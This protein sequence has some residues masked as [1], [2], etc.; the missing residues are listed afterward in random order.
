ME[1]ETAI[2]TTPVDGTPAQTI[3]ILHSS[4]HLSSTHQV[5]NNKLFPQLNDCNLLTKLTG[6]NFIW[7]ILSSAPLDLTERFTLTI[8]ESN[9]RPLSLA[10]AAVA[11]F[12]PCCHI[13][14]N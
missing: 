3:T 1:T 2:T 4:F 9:S 13:A 7:T 5:T 6:G 11:P 12:C 8:T 10:C 14:V